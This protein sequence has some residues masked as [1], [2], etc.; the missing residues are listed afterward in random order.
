MAL[1]ERSRFLRTL[2]E[3]MGWPRAACNL[4]R[5]WWDADHIVP[6]VEGGGICGLENYRTLCLKCHRQATAELLAR[7]REAS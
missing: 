2:V 5:S 3:E 4:R 6:V 1:K 7:R